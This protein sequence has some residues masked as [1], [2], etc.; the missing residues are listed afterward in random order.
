MQHI[1]SAE[2][3]STRHKAHRYHRDGWDLSPGAQQPWVS[4]VMSYCRRPGPVC[5]W[6]RGRIATSVHGNFTSKYVGVAGSLWKLVLE[7]DFC[8][9]EMSSSDIPRPSPVLSPGAVTAVQ[10][11]DSSHILVTCVPL[12]TK[13]AAGFVAWLISPL[14][15]FPKIKRKCKCGKGL[16]RN[17][18]HALV[19]F[20]K[21]KKKIVILCYSL[22]L[23]SF[24]VTLLFQQR[25]SMIFLMNKTTFLCSRNHPANISCWKDKQ[26]D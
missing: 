26:Q 15:Y 19:T 11:Q 25:E 18:C 14:Q 23:E 2:L 7:A 24:H 4:A 10:V 13:L 20:S 12:Q 9:C 5:H 8:G 3:H 17:F 1:H 22:L 6:R 16:S 21:K